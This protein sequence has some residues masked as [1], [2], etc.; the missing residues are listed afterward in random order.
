MIKL[1][2]LTEEEKKKPYA[3]FLNRKLATPSKEVLK[4]LKKREAMD[5]KYVLLPENNNM[6]DILKDGYLEY[7]Y[8]YCTLP[9]GGGY[10]AMLNKMPGV[11]FE[12]Y[13]FWLKWW[14]AGSDSSL[15]YR[16]WNP[17][18]H[19]K[20]GFRWS[21]EDVGEGIEDLVFLYQLKPEN[22]G[23]SKEIV[24]RSSL[25][26][27]DG[28]NVISKCINAAPLSAPKPGVVCHFVRNM[29]DG[30]GIELRSR[31]WKGFQVSDNGLFNAMG[32]DTPKET[33][34]SLY[35]LAEHNAYE[36]AHLAS[37]LPELY[38][39]EKHTIE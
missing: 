17:R 12:M 3:K 38:E 2:E 1:P 29:E 39:M 9:N 21:S 37:I 6:N 34:E 33:E 7:E 36:M 20:A 26:L 10:V 32:P 23:L 22:L 31:F 13:K 4:F 16:I 24:E 28:G 8:G 27:A 15:R 5:K 14:T 25:L 18:D 11:T 30:S 19:Y 35:K